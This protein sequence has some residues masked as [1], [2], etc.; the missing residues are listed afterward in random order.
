MVAMVLFNIG[1]MSHYRGD[2]AADR[3]INGGRYVQAHGTGWEV[4]NFLARDGRCRGYVKIPGNA[5]RLEHLGGSPDA[6][7]VGGATVVFCATR[8]GGGGYVVGWYSNAL[9]WRKYQPQYPHPFIAEALADDCTLLDVDDRVFRVPRARDGAFGLGRSNIRYLHTPDAEPFVRDLRGYIRSHGRQ[10]PIS[11][12]PSA[13]NP[14]VALRKQV[15]MAAVRH[16]KAH[17]ES[18]GFECHS[19]EQDNVGWDFV[20]TKKD[21]ELLVEVKGRSGD[22]QVELTPNEYEAMSN[23]QIRDRYRLAI[24]SAALQ[25]PVLSII[26]YNFSDQQWR[27]Q[28]GHAATLTERVGVRIRLPAVKQE[29]N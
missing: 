28:H 5:I 16:V 12:R 15:E 1:W 8:P 20:C 26:S 2:K 11:R 17:Y 10:P 3:L 24:V 7:N 25:A 9:V 29:S 21:L 19:V 13:Q 4:E 23:R 6:P 14:N 27:D 18:R 22:T